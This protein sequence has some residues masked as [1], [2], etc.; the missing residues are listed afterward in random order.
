M[1]RAGFLPYGKILASSKPFNAPLGGLI[2]H[3]IPSVVV[4][5]LPPS[6]DVYAFIAEIE[7]YTGQFFA[8]AVA[9]GLVILRFREPDTPRPFR[10]WLSA[11]YVRIA[12]CVSLIIAPLIPSRQSGGKIKLFDVA[13]AFVSISTQVFPYLSLFG[14][15]DVATGS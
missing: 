13:Y 2:V 9:I 5:T 14:S 6:K 15:A 1:A 7:A 4:I 12:L 8:L 10:A 3:Y 11:V